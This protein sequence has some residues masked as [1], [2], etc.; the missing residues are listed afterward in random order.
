MTD[1]PQADKNAVASISFSN[2]SAIPADLATSLTQSLLNQPLP[3]P[4]QTVGIPLP[5]VEI[6]S[7]KENRL[8]NVELSNPS[9]ASS[10]PRGDHAESHKFSEPAPGLVATGFSTGLLASSGTNPSTASSASSQA[11]FSA[12][13]SRNASTSEFGKIIT[14]LIPEALPQPIGMG[15]PTSNPPG[16]STPGH[17]GGSDKGSSV[18]RARIFTPASARAIDE[19]DEPRR[20]SPLACAVTAAQAVEAQE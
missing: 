11:L 16:G 3:L 7:R 20:G 13:V 1:V 9:L 15:K 8:L 10:G 19:E 2:K 12:S 4:T 5:A 14:N 6:K 18:K 17:N